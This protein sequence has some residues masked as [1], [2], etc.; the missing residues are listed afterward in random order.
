MQLDKYIIKN[1]FVSVFVPKLQELGKNCVLYIT[2][3]NNFWSKCQNPN[4]YVDL[5][6]ESRYNDYTVT[7]YQRKN[8]VCIWN[9]DYL[10]WELFS[11]TDSFL[12]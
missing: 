6:N 3:Q 5:I 8:D 4:S 9:D 11:G 2:L 7:F 12:F 1:A 10:F